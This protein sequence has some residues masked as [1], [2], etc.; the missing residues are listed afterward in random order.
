MVLAYVGI[1]VLGGGSDE[2]AESAAAGSAT[3]QP[4]STGT[5][6]RADGADPAG[7][8]GTAGSTTARAASGS[9]ADESRTASTPRPSPTTWAQEVAA[10]GPNDNI[11]LT[12][13]ASDWTAE[14]IVIG[15][16][17][18]GKFLGRVTVRYAGPGTAHGKFAVTLLKDGKEI[19]T[20]TGE[21]VEVRSGTYQVMLSTPASWVEGPWTTEFTVLS[22]A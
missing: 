7:A 12:P 18:A 15:K 6:D 8:G 1:A 2:Q 22:T 20:L 5:R 11:R 14:N 19:T 10:A 16:D 13:V 9:T 4:L 17:M 3:D 21:L